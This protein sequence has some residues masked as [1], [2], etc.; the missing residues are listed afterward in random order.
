MAT[1]RLGSMRNVGEQPAQTVMRADSLLQV[2]VD[3]EGCLF[4]RRVKGIVVQ[5]CLPAN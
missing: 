5:K 3:A 4:A 2:H 1:A